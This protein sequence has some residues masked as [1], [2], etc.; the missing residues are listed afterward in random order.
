MSR[1]FTSTAAA[2][3]AAMLAAHPGPVAGL[4]PMFGPDVAAP[5]GEVVVHSPGR[6]EVGWILD[7]IARR[8]ATSISAEK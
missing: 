5:A 3:L 7:R 2:A 6:E 8:A 4:H 1:Y